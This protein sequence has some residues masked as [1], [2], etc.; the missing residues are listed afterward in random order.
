M[1]PKS[2]PNSGKPRTFES[3]A[4][5]RQAVEDA[6]ADPTPSVPARE[7]FRRLRDRHAAA[8]VAGASKLE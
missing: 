5:L 7:V 1:S 3:T 2:Q 8:F 6:L 4:G